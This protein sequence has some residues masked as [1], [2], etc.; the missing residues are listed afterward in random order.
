MWIIKKFSQKNPTELGF[1]LIFNYPIN[2]LGIIN[3][4]TEITKYISKNA[5]DCFISFVPKVT[6]SSAAKNLAAIDARHPKIG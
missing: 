6:S 4:T 5:T 2:T 1:Y 3:N